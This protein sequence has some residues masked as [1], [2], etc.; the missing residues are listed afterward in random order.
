MG[1]LTFDWS[2]DVAAIQARSG[3]NTSAKTDGYLLFQ[4]RATADSQ[5]QTR[6]RIDSMLTTYG[7]VVP[8]S[9]NTFD[10]G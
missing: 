4:T 1:H 5:L 6:L 2:V 8:S 9:T 3:V 10:L 7:S